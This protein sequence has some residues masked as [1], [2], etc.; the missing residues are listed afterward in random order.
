MCVLNVYANAPHRTSANESVWMSLGE[1]IA[2][3]AAGAATIAFLGKVTKDRLS[4]WVGFCMHPIPPR[5][6]DHYGTCQSAQE[7]I[8]YANAVLVN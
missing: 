3:A 2:V 5:R 1:C 8:L 4:S 7:P 6:V